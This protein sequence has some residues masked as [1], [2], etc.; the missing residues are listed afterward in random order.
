MIPTVRVYAVLGIKGGV[1]KS[2]IAIA[3]AKALSRYYNVGLVDCDID[4]SNVPGMLD[5]KEGM[6]LSKDGVRFIPVWVTPKLK[7]VSLESIGFGRKRAAITKEGKQHQQIIRDLIEQTVWG[8]TQVLIADMPA[9]SSDEFLGV[10]SIFDHLDG[11]IAVAQPS[12]AEDFHRVIDLCKY[13]G[14][15]LMG[16]IE[17]M[18]GTLT[19]CGVPAAC[20]V[21]HKEFSPLGKD[22][23]RDIC[24]QKGVTYLG[25]IP[26]TSGKLDLENYLEQIGY[27]IRNIMSKIIIGDEVCP[28]QPL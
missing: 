6:K 4:S 10:M 19:E 16:V 28:T 9:G 17:N 15:N 26:L 5:A 24:M 27:P 8:R 14:I 3:L 7:M 21:C 11:C 18:N 25:G 13:Y 23:I 20:P 22:V 1:G 12:T 2:L